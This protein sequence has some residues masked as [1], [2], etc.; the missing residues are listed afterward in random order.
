MCSIVRAWTVNY[1]FFC[2]LLLLVIDLGHQGPGA[3]LCSSGSFNL[4]VSL[5]NETFTGNGEFS[6]SLIVSFQ[7]G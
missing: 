1:F 6:V 4:P 5:I 3:S 7:S 2:R